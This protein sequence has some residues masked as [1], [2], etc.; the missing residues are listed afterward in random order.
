VHTIAAA[1]HSQDYRTPREPAGTP[2]SVAA[3]NSDLPLDD[4]GRIKVG[5]DLRALGTQDVW[6]AGDSAVP[7]LTNPGATTPPTAQ[8]ALRQARHLA[9][10][11]VAVLRGEPHIPIATVHR[12]RREPRALQGSRPTARCPTTR[13][14]CLDP[15]PHPSPSQDA[16]LEPQG[17]DRSG[18]DTGLTLRSRPGLFRGRAR[19]QRTRAPK[20][21]TS[22]QATT[23]PR[24]RLLTV[25]RPPNSIQEA[26]RLCGGLP[27]E[28]KR[29]DLAGWDINRRAGATG[30]TAEPS[31][32][33]DS[34]ETQ[35]TSS[36]AAVGRLNLY[37]TDDKHCSSPI[38]CRR[39][40]VVAARFV[41]AAQLRP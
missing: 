6:S 1:L 23:Q 19:T 35:S 9:D 22:S 34:S 10:N 8:H 17:T 18:L 14:A 12:V 26:H 37:A 36:C 31:P 13:C 11:L 20:K 25:C 30:L 5:T 2:R 21:S 32:R 39:H 24:H 29:D 41:P 16:D 28:E 38:V 33:P 4:K 27:G 40:L 15:G 7:D 3:V